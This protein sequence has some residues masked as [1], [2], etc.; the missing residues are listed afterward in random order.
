MP[1]EDIQTEPVPAPSPPSPPSPPLPPPRLTRA[2]RFSILVAALALLIS[3]VTAW[4]THASSTSA[5]E[6]LTSETIKSQY[7]IFLDLNRVQVEQWEVG[8][9]FALPDTY[10]AAAHDVAAALGP[11]SPQRHAELM[12]RERAIALLIFTMFE[13]GF[14]QQ[15]QAAQTGETGRAQF[16]QEMLDYYTGRLLRNPR[17]MYYWRANGGGLVTYFERETRDC[18]NHHV[19]GDSGHAPLSDDVGPYQRQAPLPSP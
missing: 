12:L 2:E 18:Y 17:L 10:R 9:L 19:L 11:L 7:D 3:G 8:H 13:H 15:K 16:L 6:A 1:T 5:N 4:D 14:F